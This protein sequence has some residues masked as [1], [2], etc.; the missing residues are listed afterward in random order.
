MREQPPVLLLHNFIVK[1]SA[2]THCKVNSTQRFKVVK[3][4]IVTNC[5]F[6]PLI[7]AHKLTNTKTKYSTPLHRG[8]KEHP[9]QLCL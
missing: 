8:D 1:K 4:D 9:E 2:Y 7:T 5:Y 6:L 3:C